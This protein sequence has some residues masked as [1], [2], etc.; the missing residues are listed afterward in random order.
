MSCENCQRLE[1]QNNVCLGLLRR[2]YECHQR[3]VATE[4]D[5]PEFCDCAWCKLWGEVRAIVEVTQ[6]RVD[7]PICARLG[8]GWVRSEH[9]LEGGRGCSAFVEKGWGKRLEETPKRV[10]GCPM[11]TGAVIAGVPC[12]EHGF[13]G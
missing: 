4:G 9:K 3:D 11:C 12:P 6:K 2:F 10:D 1:L 7:D 13:R 8:C 5:H